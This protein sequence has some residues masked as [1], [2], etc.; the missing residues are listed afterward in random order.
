LIRREQKMGAPESE[1]ER[2]KVAIMKEQPETSAK[3]TSSPSTGRGEE[4]RQSKKRKSQP[5]LG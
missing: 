1:G 4:E 3:R 5:E 2:K